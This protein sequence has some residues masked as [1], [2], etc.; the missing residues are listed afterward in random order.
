M[1]DPD[2]GYTVYEQEI[3]RSDQ[4]DPLQYG[5]D[6]DGSRSFLEQYSALQKR[7]P[8][9][10]MFNLDTENCTYVNYAPHCKNCYLL[11]GCRFDE[12]CY[13][14]Q[15]MNEC[16]NCI[17][18][19]YVDKSEYCYENVDCNNNYNS[20]FCQDCIHATGS[21]FCFDC[22]N[23]SNCIGCYN[24]RNKEYHILNK[25]VSKEEFQQ[26]KEKF[27]SYLALMERKKFY[28]DHIQAN[29]IFRSYRGHNNQQVSGD[30]I[31]ESKNIKEC[32]SVYRS[33]DLAYCARMFEG[34]DSYDFDGGGKSEL[35]Y[36]NMSNDF[37]YFSI[38]GT[39][40]EHLT[41]A[42]YC[43]LCFNCEHCFGCVGLRKKAYCI[44]NKQYTKEEYES[45]L[46]KIIER[47]MLDKER[48]E[49][50]D[51]K[52]SPFAYNET[53]AYEYFPLEKKEAL[54]RGYKRRDE[55]QKQ[56]VAQTYIIPDA[57]SDVADDIVDQVLQ[58]EISKKNYKIIPQ[59][60][61]FYRKM[62]LPIPRLHP[63]QRHLERMALRNPRKLRDRKCMKC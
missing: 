56:Y 20:F 18:N 15:T 54:K 39:T 3:R 24:L 49:F 6:F 25:P 7:V 12:D 46:P 58:C 42:H 16:K 37:S 47:M 1:Y 27:S 50:P 35:T 10:N 13:Y 40:S 55:E 21:Y 45:L 8:R 36:E 43:D 23:V 2:K 17:D 51:G 57:I 9:F 60:L 52:Y 31:Y 11:F 5:K 4:W 28:R 62:K 32:F 26:E 61:Q 14:G 53:M 59:E 44:L 63:D 48:G 19:A 38:A 34:K 41:Y 33:E 29:A 22:E 30:F